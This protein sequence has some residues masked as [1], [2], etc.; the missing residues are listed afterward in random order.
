MCDYMLFCRK[1]PTL[2]VLLIEL[3]KGSKTSQQLRAGYIFAQFILATL[4]RIYSMPLQPQYRS[5]YLRGN[6]RGEKT[7]VRPQ[8]IKYDEHNHVEYSGTTFPLKAFLK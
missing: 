6:A 4:M 1:G 7:H 8:H 3:K 2:Y 5:I